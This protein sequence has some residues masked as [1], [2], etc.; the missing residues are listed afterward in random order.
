MKGRQPIPT[1]ILKAKG[2]FRKDRHEN[3]KPEVAGPMGDAPPG[4]CPVAAAEWQRVT[5]SLSAAGVGQQLDIAS[6]ACYC[7]SYAEWQA[8]SKIVSADGY[9]YTDEGNRKISRL[10]GQVE[11]RLSRLAQQFGFTPASRAR[12]PT[13]TADEQDDKEDKFFGGES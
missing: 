13:V 7:R 1:A 4:L 2:T 6:L 5:A 3:R 10:L 9:D 8:L 12:V 11:D